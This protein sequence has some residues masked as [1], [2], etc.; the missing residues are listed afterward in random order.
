MS[1]KRGGS[2]LDCRSGR[3]SRPNPDSRH[4]LFAS[5]YACLCRHVF[6]AHFYMFFPPHSSFFHKKCLSPSFCPHSSSF[7]PNDH[8]L[9][10]VVSITKNNRTH[11][12]PNA[13]NQSCESVLC[14]PRIL[15]RIAS[16]CPFLTIYRLL[17]SC[18]TLRTLLESDTALWMRFFETL[19]SRPLPFPT[20]S[21]SG[22]V[23]LD[24]PELIPWRHMC[25]AFADAVEAEK[26]RRLRRLR[27]KY[28]LMRIARNAPIVQV[29]D[30]SVVRIV[31]PFAGCSAMFAAVG[32]EFEAHWWKHWDL[33]PFVCPVCNARFAR[34]SNADRHVGVCRRDSSAEHYADDELNRISQSNDDNECE[35]KSESENENENESEEEKEECVDET[36][37]VSSL[38]G[39]SL[40]RNGGNA[41]M[42][43]NGASRR[44]TGLEEPPR[45]QRRVAQWASYK[46]LRNHIRTASMQS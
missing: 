19:S 11:N 44:N 40:M 14:V 1:I 43:G 5:L 2:R 41:T 30:R 29:H 6:A 36:R 9:L 24:L 10:I 45:K 25:R 15:H 33:R 37:S 4:Y 28:P 17:R 26:N 7:S 13:M 18:Q 21:N 31:C 35:N 46:S 38:A 27:A 12:N 32:S 3:M 23:C 20:T 22:R 39:H 16:Y 34:R 8:I 42:R